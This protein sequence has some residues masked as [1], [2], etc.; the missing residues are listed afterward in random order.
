M[1]TK[2]QRIFLLEQYFHSYSYARCRLE[3]MRKFP[4]Q[5]VPNKSSISRLVSKFRATG[6]V[7]NKERN[8][9]RHV[10][11]PEK[12]DAIKELLTQ[13]PST[14]HRK[15]AAAL[16]TTP[17]TV[18]SATKLLK[19]HPYRVNVVQE[20]SP[21]DCPK[22][23]AFCKWIL[24]FTNRVADFDYFFFSDEA[25]FT[26]DGYVNS[27][28]YRVWSASNPHAYIDKSLHP[29][30]I[31]VWCAVSRR[32]IVGPLFFEQT[33]DSDLYCDLIQQF[34]A[35]L[36][37]DE[38]D[39]IF[40]QDSARPHTSNRSMEFLRSFFGDRLVSKG[41]WPPRSPDLT[42]LDFFLWGTLK[43]NVFKHVPRSIEQLK[44]LITQEI[45]NISVRSLQNAFRSLL[46]RAL[47]CK[48]NL[49]T[50][51]QHLL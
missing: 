19:L 41:L 49:G 20:L 14:S 39:I 1:L 33:I 8:R 2:N 17:S 28:N 9:R 26:L 47:I 32:R 51:F 15:A 44:Q 43:N 18:Y 34:I 6:S 16:N 37:E 42:P 40:Q 38:R 48:N 11:T 7:L 22:R 25:W 46:R 23:I 10:L 27:Q 29:P 31:G 50:H 5:D 3:F 12:I 24:R 30:K 4:G 21:S 13:Y 35:L 36:E 45:A